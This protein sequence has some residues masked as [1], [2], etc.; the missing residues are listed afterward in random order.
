VIDEDSSESAGNRLAPQNGGEVGRKNDLVIGNDGGLVLRGGLGEEAGH[1]ADGLNDDVCAQEGTLFSERGV[2]GAEGVGDGEAERAAAGRVAPEAD[3][4]CLQDQVAGVLP[5]DA[6][7]GL[8]EDVGEL[9]RAQARGSSYE[10][11]PLGFDGEAVL[12]EQR[13]NNGVLVGKV[14]VEATDRGVAASGDG[15]HRS[16]LEADL[17]EQ[18][19]GDVKDGGESALGAL[20][21]WWP[22]DDFCERGLFRV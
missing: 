20:L 12:L 10:G 14:V 17:G 11:L 21:L 16:G 9:L 15:G 8:D 13:E 18:A 6:E 3:R 4:R 7:H 5:D 22:A 2:L 19:G 1:A